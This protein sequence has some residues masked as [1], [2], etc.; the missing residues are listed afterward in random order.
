MQCYSS[1]YRDGAEEKKEHSYLGV[2][3][4]NTG[5]NTVIAGGSA[6]FTGLDTNGGVG[7]Q[8]PDH[9]MLL[10]HLDAWRGGALLHASGDDSAQ[11]LKHAHITDTF[12]VNREKQMDH[13]KLDKRSNENNNL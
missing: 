8:I 13:K 7:R 2:L 11:R 4:P 12:L 1:S 9:A 5:I 3:K 10:D 6:P